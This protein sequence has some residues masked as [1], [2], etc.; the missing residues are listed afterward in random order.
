MITKV[1]C[2]KN[3]IHHVRLALISPIKV[4]SNVS[5]TYLFI[6]L[7]NH[8]KK[9]ARFHCKYFILTITLIKLKII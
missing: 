3:A 7:K 8:A 9:H 2:A 6:Q 1:F 4:A 5:E